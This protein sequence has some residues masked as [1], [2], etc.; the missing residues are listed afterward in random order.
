[1]KDLTENAKPHQLEKLKKIGINFIDLCREGGTHEDITEDE[2][3]VGKVRKTKKV[4]ENDY[5]NFCFC[6][7]WKDKQRVKLIKKNPNE[8][9]YIDF[10]NKVSLILGEDHLKRK[11]FN[12]ID[13]S[14]LKGEYNDFTG[15]YRT[16]LRGW[17]DSSSGYYIQISFSEDPDQDL[18]L[19][20]V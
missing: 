15:D 12:E 7:D 11:E 18:I 10:I 20:I 2:E 4:L 8:E 6:S 5:F 14:K 1:M 17:E 3:G 16:E 9:D 13:S 19:N